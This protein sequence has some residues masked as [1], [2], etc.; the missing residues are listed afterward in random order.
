MSLDD[1]C[2]ISSKELDRAKVYLKETSNDDTL[3][4]YSNQFNT[5]QNGLA[6]KPV[7]GE[8]ILAEVTAGHESPL[9][10]IPKQLSTST[11]QKS[12]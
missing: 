11:E 4:H 6:Q 7:S 10:S 9:Y 1:V 3:L 5:F 8:T 12:Y 2:Y